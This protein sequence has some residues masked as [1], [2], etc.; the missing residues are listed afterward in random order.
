MGFCFCIWIDFWTPPYFNHRI[1]DE[2]I[3]DLEENASYRGGNQERQ[4]KYQAIKKTIEKI[5]LGKYY[6]KIAKTFT[7]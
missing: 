2:Q 5:R 7:S 4:R 1:L 6:E 3:Q